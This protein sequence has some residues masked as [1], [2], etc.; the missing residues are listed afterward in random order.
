[1][2]DPM[3]EELICLHVACNV[4]SAAKGKQKLAA[5][6]IVCENPYTMRGL[7]LLLDTR[8]PFGI[9]SKSLHRK[10]K[11][12]PDREYDDL[13]DMCEDLAGKTDISDVDIANVQYFLYRIE[14]PTLR[15]FA[16]QFVTKSLPL[17]VAASTFN[18]AVGYN[19]LGQAECMLAKKYF[20][21][22]KK[23][24]GKAF[25]V[26]EK[27]DGIR[28]IASV[29]NGE[30]FI[31]SRQGV[32]IQGLVEVESDL[33]RLYRQLKERN[34]TL[35]GEL[36]IDNR[37]DYPSKE[38]YKRTTMIV[39][40]DGEKHGI[41]YHV[42]DCMGYLWGT[43]DISCES[44]SERRR[45]LQEWCFC[46]A[47]KFTHLHLVPV[48]Y[49]GTDTKQILQEL[50]IQ[51]KLGHEGVMVNLNDE[52]YEIGRSSAIF[53]VK[54]MQ[55]CDLKIVG[56]EEGAGRLHGT[57]GN[58]LVDYKGT[59]VGVGTGFTDEDRTVFWNNK[60]EF[61]GRVVTIQY[62]EE[63]CDAKG[64]PSIRFP[65]YKELREKGKEVSYS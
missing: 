42:F 27:L 51:R 35:D 15:I 17:G 25:T 6:K 26:T 21:H 45:F 41:T 47:D 1:M 63:T 62:F 60:Q 20:E 2:G 40:K 48:L 18:K 61:I 55:D 31:N 16:D 36:I 29:V 38:Q 9:R 10:V 22:T 14:E 11:A 34:F 58:L 50:D 52:P 30:V 43:H 33:L 3:T 32:P 24:E 44:Y 28:A 59:T 13:L 56:M 19:A 57:L 54:V 12:A 4:V 65:V 37:D 49:S 8:T 53:K 46:N 64:V 5:L 23:V 39:R 7:M